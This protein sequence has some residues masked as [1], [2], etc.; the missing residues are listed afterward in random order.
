MSDRHYRTGP[1]I[2]V[3]ILGV[4]LMAG[5]GG[6]FVLARPVLAEAVSSTLSTPDEVAGLTLSSNPELQTVADELKTGIR[7]EV[8]NSTGSIG[9][10]YTDPADTAKIVMLAGV[11]GVVA[12]PASELGRGFTGISEGG[13][14]ITNLHD[15]D[16]GPLGGEAKC[17]DSTANG[18]ALIVCGWADDASIAFALFFNREAAASEELFRQI[19]GEILTRG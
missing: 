4:L 8:T 12:D 16:P 11:T 14:Q 17:G 13:M 1:W 7:E 9:A 15:V 19:R 5:A 6:F 2:A 18:Q 10:F 3:S